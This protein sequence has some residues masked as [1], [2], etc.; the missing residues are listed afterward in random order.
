[1][2][3]AVIQLTRGPRRFPISPS[4]EWTATSGR[5]SAVVQISISGAGPGPEDRAELCAYLDALK[6]M[7]GGDPGAALF[8]EDGGR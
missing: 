3:A 5:S 4:S 2:T 7:L 6:A 1:V 8:G